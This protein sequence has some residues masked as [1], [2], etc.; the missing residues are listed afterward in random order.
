MA[1]TKTLDTMT[2]AQLN[3]RF[4]ALVQKGADSY[5]L[6][7][8]SDAIEAA[9]EREE[10]GARMAAK[11]GL[12]KS[13]LNI[14]MA[15]ATEKRIQAKARKAGDRVGVGMFTVTID[16]K[17]ICTVQAT[18]ALSLPGYGN[19]HMMTARTALGNI[20]Q[21]VERHG[22]ARVGNARARSMGAKPSLDESISSLKLTIADVCRRAISIGVVTV[23]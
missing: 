1:T 23:A 3:E 19:D 17:V 20:W 18:P 2:L 13:R 9:K 7:N 12:K 6:Q 8:V 10:A 5:Q 15:A 4:D 21:A 22:A 16:G 11:A 14:A